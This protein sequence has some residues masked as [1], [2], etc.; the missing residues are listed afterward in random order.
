MA[1]TLR[2]GLRVSRRD[3]A[4][5]QVGLD[6]RGAA[7][8]HPRDPGGA[9]P[10]RGRV[11][12][13]TDL[14]RPRRR[15]RRCCAR[16]T[17]SS[18][19]ADLRPGRAGG[20]RG[21][22]QRRAAPPGRR[23][24]AT[25]TVVAIGRRARAGAVGRRRSPQL[26]RARGHRAPR[27]TPTR[28][29]PWRVLLCSAASPTGRL[30]GPADR[31]RSAAPPGGDPRR[32]G[33]GRARSWCPGRP[34]ACAASTRTSTSATDAGAW[35]CTGRSPGRPDACRSRSTRAARGGAR[36]PGRGRRSSTATGRRPGRR[37]R[38]W[39]GPG[40]RPRAPRVAA[41]SAL[42][43]LLGRPARPPLA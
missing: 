26:A 19:P 10:P 16:A 17:W 35:C 23:A 24:E 15:A 22:R 36:G 41:P 11:R 21:A 39:S 1:E 3:D 38:P 18:T 28:P 4:T 5:L 33:P 14:P 27:P 43:L 20:L 12:R 32:R 42:R 29:P 2:P 37:R 7:A 31:H 13:R 6:R 8:R 9:A 40:A 25:V 34:P 30:D